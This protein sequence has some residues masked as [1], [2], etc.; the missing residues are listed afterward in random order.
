MNKRTLSDTSVRFDGIIVY[1]ISMT[2]YDEFDQFIYKPT[3][4]GIIIP[5]TTAID[6]SR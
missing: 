6:L 5:L 2:S 4:I 3:L 1:F